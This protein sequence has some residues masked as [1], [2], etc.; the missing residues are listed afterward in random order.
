MDATVSTVGIEIAQRPQLMAQ[1]QNVATTFG[2]VYR[3]ANSS[4]LDQIFK[5]LSEVQFSPVFFPERVGF[6]MSTNYE[7]V[8]VFHDS[9]DDPEVVEGENETTL[10]TPLALDPI[11][12][13]T[14]RTILIQVKGAGNLTVRGI[15]KG[16]DL[17]TTQP[18]ECFTEAVATGF[19]KSNPVVESVLDAVHYEAATAKILEAFKQIQ[20]IEVPQSEIPKIKGLIKEI[21][22]HIKA[23]LAAVT[24]PKLA[25]SLIQMNAATNRYEDLGKIISLVVPRNRLF[26]RSVEEQQA[27]KI[28]SMCISRGLFL[29]GCSLLQAREY[30]KYSHVKFKGHYADRRT[31]MLELVDSFHET[32][33]LPMQLAA[34]VADYMKTVVVRFNSASSTH[35]TVLKTEWDEKAD[36][37]K[38]TALSTKEELYRVDNKG[39]LLDDAANSP[40]KGQKF[41]L[42]Q[43]LAASNY[44]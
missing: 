32:T 40:N 27:E 6:E 36:K 1:L 37:S 14:S 9:K 34:I 17:V 23:G 24:N 39:E 22:T 7:V 4:N 15:C 42:D 21:R 35:L 25:Q 16:R 19:A 29:V 13:R 30:L 2:G 11:V 31:P 8:K 18:E 10:V 12:N 43:V 38:A 3:D 44:A 26:A 20:E 28:A 5:E 41:T 33:G